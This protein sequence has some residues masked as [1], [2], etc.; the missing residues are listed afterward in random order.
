M[1]DILSDPYVRTVSSLGKGDGM[2]GEE[3]AV[4]TGLGDPALQS[5][6]EEV[7]GAAVGG[8]TGQG[9][10]LVCRVKRE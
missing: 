10:A 7:S 8:P 2:D 1:T 9:R 5:L 3:S 4:E 6:F